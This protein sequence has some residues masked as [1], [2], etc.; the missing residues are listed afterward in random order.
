[1][2]TTT[3]TTILAILLAT[4]GVTHAQ[5]RYDFDYRISDDR[6]QVFDDGHNTRITLPEGTLTPTVIAAQPIGEVLLMPSRDGT[7]LVFDGIYKRLTIRWANGR[8]VIANYQGQ[9]QMTVRNGSPASFGSAQPVVAYGTPPPPTH[10]QANADQPVVSP[11]V[12]PVVAVAK[13]PPVAV[14]K[15]VEFNDGDERDCMLAASTRECD[16]TKNVATVGKSVKVDAPVPATSIQWAIRSSDGTLSKTLA[17]WAQG[18]TPPIAWEA[19]KDFPALAATY[20]GT[21]LEAIEQVMQ[22]TARSQFP[23]HACVYDN[24]VRVLHTSQSCLR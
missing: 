24:V 15:T 3:Q 13:Q 6:I 4:T 9:N 23:L 17:R 20:S 2:K 16:A 11:P 12:K 7:N 19:D 8:E 21:Y 18:N 1:M 5:A 22:D 10:R 14:E